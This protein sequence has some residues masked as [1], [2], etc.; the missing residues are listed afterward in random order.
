MKWFYLFIAICAISPA[1]AAELASDRLLQTEIRVNSKVRPTSRVITLVALNIDQPF[2]VYDETYFEELIAAALHRKGIRS[3]SRPVR[4]WE[5]LKTNQTPLSDALAPKLVV[6]LQVHRNGGDYE[7]ITTVTV[8]AYQKEATGLVLKPQKAWSKNQSFVGATPREVTESLVRATQA[9]IED[10]I[11]TLARLT[12]LTDSSS[13]EVSGGVRSKSSGNS[14]SYSSK[15]NDP[16]FRRGRLFTGISVGTPA[17]L[18]LHLGYWGTASLP[19]VV[20]LSGMYLSDS[21]RGAQL[22][23]GWAFDN[24]GHFKQG[25]GLSFSWLTNTTTSQQTQT[26]VLGRVTSVD[27]ITNISMNTFVGPTYFADFHSFHIQT[28]AAL[29]INGSGSTAPRFLFQI[30]FI[31]PVGF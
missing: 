8:I 1:H 17:I 28:G 30:G 3:E 6:D 23:L 21:S 26:D 11:P 19:I 15:W 13:V 5:R 7:A 31:P 12:R 9:A 24:E 4:W 22:E 10:S 29:P 25:I 14:L 20:N 27:Q 2:R 16:D 18:N